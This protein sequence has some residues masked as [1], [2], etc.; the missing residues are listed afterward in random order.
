L[1]HSPALAKDL[2]GKHILFYQEP[3]PTRNF[4]ATCVLS[5]KLSWPENSILK[6]FQIVAFVGWWRMGGEVGMLLF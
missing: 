3:P 5:M 4:M 1:L 2:K 6:T